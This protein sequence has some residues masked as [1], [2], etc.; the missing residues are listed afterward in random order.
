MILKDLYDSLGLAMTFKDFQ[1][2]QDYFKNEEKRNP[3]YDRDQS[4]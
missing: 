3:I 1:F 2:I 4:A